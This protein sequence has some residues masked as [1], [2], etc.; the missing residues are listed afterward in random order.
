MKKWYTSK[1]VWVG[2]FQILASI[3]LIMS[4]SMVNSEYIS[5]ILA[6]NGFLGIALRWITDKPITSPIKSLDNLRPEIKLNEA[7]RRY[8]IK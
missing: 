4:E 2:I 5:T 7:A 1:T 6:V 3:T 8:I